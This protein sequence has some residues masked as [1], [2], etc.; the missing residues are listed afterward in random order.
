MN[1]FDVQRLLAAAN[2]YR[3]AI[4]GVIGDQSKR[5]IQKVLEEHVARDK[6]DSWS[7]SRRAIAAGQRI[8][9]YAGYT[10]VGAVDGR[11]GNATLGAMLEWNHFQVYR[12]PLELDRTPV[13]SE[14]LNKTFPR[15][16]DCKTFYGMPGKEIV[17]RLTTVHVPYPLRLDWDLGVLKHTVRLHER[18]ADSGEEAFRL[19]LKELG[20][21]R[22]QNLGLDR[23]A[24][25]HAHRTMRGGTSW[26]MHAYGCALDFFAQPNGLTTRCPQALFCKP[27]YKVFF[28][29]WE[30]LGWTSLGRAIGR[31]W[32]H[33]QAARL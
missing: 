26:S 28:D 9:Y 11:V 2:Y 19:I 18:C 15:Q 32:M 5:A 13:L 23:F 8:L 24:G 1:M 16:V 6:Y 21:I 30:S 4:D 27:E 10:S 29:I 17:N 12:K 22:I 33:V 31:D 7:W 3:G 20:L 25:D 14:G